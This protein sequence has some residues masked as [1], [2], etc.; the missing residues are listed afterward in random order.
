MKIAKK[1]SLSFLVTAIII[2]SVVGPALYVIFSNIL[3]DS[4]FAHLSTTAQSRRNHIETLLRE[5]EHAGKMLAL[6]TSFK[7]VFNE[8]LDYDQ[9]MEAALNKIETVL[10]THMD[11]FE[12]LIFDEK[13]SVLITNEP[14]N[15]TTD[16]NRLATLKTEEKD[17]YLVDLHV[18]EPSG[19]IG[20]C[21]IAPIYIENER[22]G[23]ICFRIKAD[24][25][26]SILTDKTGLGKTGEI[27]LVNR[28]GYMISPSRFLEDTF[29]NTKVDTTSTRKYFEDVREFGDTK[30][31]HIPFIHAD[32]R[33][34]KVLGVHD[35]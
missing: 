34:K 32:Y 19:H 35:H 27:Y 16:E 13:G 14:R 22:K 9:R 1:I 23:F 2:V 31:P 17:A 21:I 24:E 12:I 28:D 29:K 20:M 4:I 18:L 11:F 15:V 33:G 3:K 5:Y 30:H 26:Y 8:N 6:S 25:I 10:D 7:N